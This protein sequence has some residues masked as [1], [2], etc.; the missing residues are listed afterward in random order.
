MKTFFEV[1]H[2]NHWITVREKVLSFFSY[3]ISLF[4][5]VSLWNK[6]LAQRD[7]LKCT[8]NCLSLEFIVELYG[9][10]SSL[11][12]KRKTCT[13]TGDSLEGLKQCGGRIKGKIVYSWNSQSVITECHKCRYLA[14]RWKSTQ[15]KGKWN[16]RMEEFFGEKFNLV[17]E[18]GELYSFCSVH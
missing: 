13:G 9:G 12:W 8:G 7:I 10:E 3:N 2:E 16:V 18:F 6:F 15:T 11:T 1:V 17:G 4:R 5:F 14:R